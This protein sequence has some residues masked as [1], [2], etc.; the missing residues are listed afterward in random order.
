M[1]YLDEARWLIEGK[2]GLGA[3]TNEKMVEAAE[4][5]LRDKGQQI[6]RL[7]AEVKRLREQRDKEAYGHLMCLDLANGMGDD[8]KG[9]DAST[10]SLAQEAVLKLRN[11]FLRLRE[12]VRELEAGK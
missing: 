10:W 11:E 12:R 4:R 7:E 2:W 6:E 1:S 8:G 5:M 3:R 9:F